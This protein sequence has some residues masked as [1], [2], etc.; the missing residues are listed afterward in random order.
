[1]CSSVLEEIGKF[2]KT[3]QAKVKAREDLFFNLHG[4][5][6]EILDYVKI[7]PEA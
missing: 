3:V 2:L 6:E 7:Q 1:M 4:K 5:T